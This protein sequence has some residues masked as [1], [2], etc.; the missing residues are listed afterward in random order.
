MTLATTLPAKAVRSPVRDFPSHSSLTPS[1]RQPTRI[2]AESRA[3]VSLPLR[4]APISTRP[5]WSCLAAR[6][7]ASATDSGDEPGAGPLST[8]LSP[9]TL[10]R[11]DPISI[12]FTSEAVCF[13]TS[14]AADAASPAT[15]SFSE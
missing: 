2:L 15:A 3:A 8:S 4:V 5:G 14:D 13:A 10:E 6:L 7:I 1:E 9:E 11:R 12:T